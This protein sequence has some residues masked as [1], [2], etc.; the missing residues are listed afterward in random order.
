MLKGVVADAL[1]G[2]AS[3][4]TEARARAGVII[5]QPIED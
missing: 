5:L 3:G 2:C 1:A 4:N